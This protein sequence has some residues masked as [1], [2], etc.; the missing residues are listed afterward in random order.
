MV[1]IP[2]GS[3]AVKV[4]SVQ[5]AIS[6]RAVDDLRDTDLFREDKVQ[7]TVVA[8]PEPVQRR[9]VVAP[10]L[11]NVSPRSRT[12]R[13]VFE[14]LEPFPDPSLCIAGE[15]LELAGG[16]LGEEHPTLRQEG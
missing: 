13:V 7:D 14:G 8:D 1:S 3:F 2:L 6:L 4:A 12:N 5:S 10:K 9:V 15:S 16:G 11:A